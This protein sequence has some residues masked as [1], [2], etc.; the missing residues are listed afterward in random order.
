MVCSDC[1]NE[2][3]I[4]WRYDAWASFEIIGVDAEGGLIKS[5]DFDTQVFDDNKIECSKCGR[6][7]T[8]REIVELLRR[9]G[10]Q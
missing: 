5:T 2:G 7:F 10:P 8:E 9:A 4:E 1:G 3:S 6:L